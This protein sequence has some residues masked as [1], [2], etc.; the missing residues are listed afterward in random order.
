MSKAYAFLW[1]QCSKAM[2]NKIK[3]HS[4]GDMIKNHPINLL[5]A[6]KE[7]ALNFQ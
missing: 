5:L 4:S 2:Q 3:A 7:H 6:I 1:E